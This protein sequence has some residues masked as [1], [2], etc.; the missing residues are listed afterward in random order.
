MR[1]STEAGKLQGVSDVLVGM[2]TELNK[3]TLRNVDLLTGEAEAASPN[4]LMVGVRAEDNGI[5]D[6]VFKK[7]EEMFSSKKNKRSEDKQKKYERIE[8]VG[9]LNEG[10][11]MAVISVPGT[12]A[13]REAKNALNQGMHVFLF[14]DNVT[15]EEE[16]ELKD[17]AN[18]RGLLLMGPDCGTAIINGVPLGFANR[19]RRG[20]IGIV[21]ASGTGTQQVTTLIDTLGA[22]VSQVIGTGGRDLSQKVGGRT[23]LSALDAL[24]EDGATEV[25]VIISKPPAPEVA[26]KIFDKAGNMKKKVILCLLGAKLMDNLPENIIQCTSLEET[27]VRASSIAL[28]SEV[29]LNEKENNLYL[30]EEFKKIRK[31]EQKYVRALFGGGTLCDETMTL[32]RQ[33]NIPMFSNIPLDESEALEDVEKSQGNTFLDMGDDYFTRGK[34]HPMI[35]PSLRTKRIITDALDRSTAVML[36]DIELGHGCHP[37]PAGVVVTGAEEA[38]TKLQMENRRV[39]WIAAL[40]GTADDPQNMQEQI[41]KLKDAGF[42]VYESN[43]RAAELA[44]SLVLE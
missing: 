31:P 15:V 33:R 38:N 22:G 4:D 3:D 16:I 40:I 42:V 39:M 1:I 35:E 29:Y 41:K 44:A 21:G 30:I 32:F 5:I 7:I 37:D 25:V 8:E 10:Y 34:P 23:T 43:I 14:S 2:G 11:N 26:D 24:N 18:K 27:A 6:E 12:Y 9:K 36:L 17:H 13:A 20:K 28:N 19:V